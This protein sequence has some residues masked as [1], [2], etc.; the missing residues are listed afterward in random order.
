MTYRLLRDIRL[1]EAF[2]EKDRADLVHFMH[3]KHYAA[4][5]TLCTR[6]EHGNTMIVVVQGALSAV[7]LGSDSR[8]REIAHLCQGAVFGEM[9]CLDPA[10][11]PATVIASEPATVLELGCD[12]LIKMRQQAPHIAAALISAVF[13]SVLKHL[14]SL[15]DRIARE[16]RALNHSSPDD[17][18]GLPQPA[19]T[20]VLDPWEICFA[21]LRGSA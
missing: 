16:L 10:P 13:H 17:G 4:G 5:D 20:N 8:P 19:R 1:F 21:R 11:R 14:R 18:P 9:F 12:D 2:S 15:D 7:A 3:E 6:G